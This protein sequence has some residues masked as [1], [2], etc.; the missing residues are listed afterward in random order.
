[1]TNCRRKL[2]RKLVLIPRSA[3]NALHSLGLHAGRQGSSSFPSHSMHHTRATTEAPSVRVNGIKQNTPSP[4]DP[5]RHHQ[6]LYPGF[7]L[8]A[9]SWS[10]TIWKRCYAPLVIA[11]GQMVTPLKLHRSSVRYSVRSFHP[12]SVAYPS[13]FGTGAGPV[14]YVA[15]SSLGKGSLFSLTHILSHFHILDYSHR[16]LSVGVSLTGGIGDAPNLKHR[17]AGNAQN[18]LENTGT[19]PVVRAYGLAGSG[20]VAFKPNR[21]A[22]PWPGQVRLN[23]SIR[24]HSR[25]FL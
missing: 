13:R 9:S 21:F 1:M 4:T 17:L 18:E 22:A 8:I 15:Q 6:S 23:S 5:T 14:E 10:S 25:L 20:P 19:R 2:Y 24:Q 16:L 3:H 11:A 12:S 7:A